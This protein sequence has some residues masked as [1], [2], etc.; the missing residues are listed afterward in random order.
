MGINNEVRGEREKGK[1]RRGIMMLEGDERAKDEMDARASLRDSVDDD[2]DDDV[3]VSVSE[4][5]SE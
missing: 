1:E 5:A 2:K 3:N 4:R